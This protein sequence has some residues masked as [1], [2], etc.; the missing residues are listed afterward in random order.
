MPWKW[1]KRLPYKYKLS[2]FTDIQV[3]TPMYKGETGATNLNKI[4]QQSLNPRGVQ[5]ERGTRL[6]RSGDKVMQIRNNYEKEVFNGD[7]GRIIKID[8]EDQFLIV[9]FDGRKTSY[10]FNELD[11]M[12]LA[13]AATVHKTQGSEYRAV[14]M[15]LS[16]QHFMML[17]RNL[18][19][20][21]V[22]RAKELLVIV[23]MVK[24]LYIAVK[25]NKVIER[26]TYLKERIRE[27]LF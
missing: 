26:Y 8:L 22:T 12:T 1:R 10:E 6:F 9:N 18:L 15:P 2:P 13:Y 20:T 4:L 23:G 17:Q 27:E 3:I 19:Y 24:A 25:N 16:T 11:Q 14:V 21:A 7:I 5:L